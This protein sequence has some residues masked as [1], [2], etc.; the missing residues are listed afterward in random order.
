MNRNYFRIV[1]ALTVASLLLII[2]YF[3]NDPKPTKTTTWIIQPPKSPYPS[4]I[5]GVGVV[6]PRSGNIAINTGLNRLVES[7][8]VQVGDQIKK[9]DI[10][11]QLENQDL[12]A[13]LKVKFLA[14]K[15]ALA[16]VK[17]LEELPRPED[18]KSAQAL[19]FTAQAQ[20]DEAKHQLERVQNLPDTRAVSMEEQNARR[21]RLEQTLGKL[22][23]AEANLEKVKAGAWKPD[24]KIARFTALQAEA[25]YEALKSEVQ[26]TTIRSPLD[27]TV[28][29]V[30]IHVGEFSSPSASF[31]PLM[32][33]GDTTAM[34][35]KVS[36][37]QLE[38][39][40]FSDKAPAVAFLQGDA[41]TKYDLT[42]VRALPFLV[43]KED[44]TNEIN[45]KVD[46]R[47]FQIVYKIENVDSHIFAGARM[48][49]FIEREGHL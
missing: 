15:N 31:A 8:Y 6:E 24:L 43:T 17:K 14:F 45:E 1:L 49:V 40:H 34:H 47:I 46:T 19:L 5:S 13:G 38:V 23:D 27:G 30:K 20:A 36:I 21:F 35:L 42:F 11:L 37:N 4:Y 29:Q 18:L 48:D 12:N 39:P 10:L 26:R 16:Q 33:I 32:I 7:V 44:V 9:G 3:V 41:R 22:A 28:L 25:D 2:F